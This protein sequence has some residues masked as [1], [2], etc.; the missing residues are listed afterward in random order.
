LKEFC[1]GCC[2]QTLKKR[3]N[4]EWLKKKETPQRQEQSGDKKHQKAGPCRSEKRTQSR[5]NAGIREWGRKKG[6]SERGKGNEG[7]KV[8]GKKEPKKDLREIL[9]RTPVK[10]EPPKMLE[11]GGNN[12]TKQKE[13]GTPSRRR[14][15]RKC[16]KTKGK[17][18]E[19]QRRN[20]KNKNETGGML[21]KRPGDKKQ[22]KKRSENVRHVE[23]GSK[24]KR[25]D[26]GRMMDE[27]E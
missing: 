9:V 25:S 5:A 20:P 19:G 7:E 14:K 21:D 23:G 1:W 15:G 10:G 13:T 24:K 12:S 6:W 17:R 16:G 8:K 3:R 26:F 4:R 27:L 11:V 18:E 22:G 2:C